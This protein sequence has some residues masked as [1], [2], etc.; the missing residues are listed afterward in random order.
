V[1]DVRLGFGDNDLTPE[2]FSVTK[3]PKIYGGGPLRRPRPRQSCTVSK[4]KEKDKM[5]VGVLYS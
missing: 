3:P 1:I 2:N 4:E 5:L